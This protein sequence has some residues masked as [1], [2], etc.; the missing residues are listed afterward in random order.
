MGVLIKGGTCRFS[1]V[2]TIRLI[3]IDYSTCRYRLFDLSVSTI[4]L[5]ENV[6]Y[7]PTHFKSENSHIDLVLSKR[8]SVVRQLFYYSKFVP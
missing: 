8:F 7:L 2:S 4:R 3:G 5:I 6:L 1:A